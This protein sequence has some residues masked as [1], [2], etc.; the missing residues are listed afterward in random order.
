MLY[1]HNDLEQLSDGNDDEMVVTF[2][3]ASLYLG[4]PQHIGTVQSST[5]YQVCPRILS[6]SHPECS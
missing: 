2:W 5:Q 1:S 3:D 6:F 4:M